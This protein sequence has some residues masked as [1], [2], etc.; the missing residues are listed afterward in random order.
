MDAACSTDGRQERCLQD[1]LRETDHF[2]D[3]GIDGRIKL[4]YFFKS[5]LG[6]HG[7]ICSDS[8]QGKVAGACEWGNEPS[9]SIPC[10]EF[11]V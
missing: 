4:K 3:L 6:R 9:G 11:L 7:L 10:R 5:E 1:D 2:E 8:G